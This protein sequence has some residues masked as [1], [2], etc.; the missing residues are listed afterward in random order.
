MEVINNKDADF[1]HRVRT[2]EGASL[3]QYAA[4][5]QLDDA[6]SYLSVIC[7][8]EELNAEDPYGFNPLMYYLSKDNFEMSA[9]LVFRGA[10][11]NHLF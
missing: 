8:H 9:K 4:K 1:L 3:I 10:N 7:T 11:V 6:V 2:S 5:G